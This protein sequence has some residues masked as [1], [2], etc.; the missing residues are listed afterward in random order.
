MH[1]F[2]RWL[3][4]D[5]GEFWAW[6]DPQ[7]RQHL[8]S[9]ADLSSLW[10]FCVRNLGFI[11]L[12]TDRDRVRL[13]FRPD[14]VSKEAIAAVLFWLFDHPPLQAVL[15]RY[16]EGWHDEIVRGASELFDRL[17]TL[18]MVAEQP[19]G[20]W[21]K[22]TPVPLTGL[23][24]TSPLHA[25][26]T[27]WPQLT[28]SSMAEIAELCDRLFGGTFTMV[29]R[30]LNHEHVITHQGFGYRIY[31]KRYLRSAIGTRIEDDPNPD[32]G[33]WVAQGLRDVLRRQQPIIED[34]DAS[35]VT[36]PTSRRVAYRRILV[37]LGIRDGLPTIVTASCL[38]SFRPVDRK[39]A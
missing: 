35:L 32:Y 11:W 13:R 31:D 22:R 20:T 30:D 1:G 14:R 38:N 33:I 36:G 15:T 3:I 8:Q 2:D 5:T 7:L 17:L 4:D 12:D 24:S 37:P 10:P 19:S 16:D 9:T 28:T 26:V 25:L 23:N 39:V 27:R 29:E 18:K 21:F 34:V 6:G